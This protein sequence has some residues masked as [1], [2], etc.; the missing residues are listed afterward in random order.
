MSAEY[1]KRV[2]RWDRIATWVIT[3][4]GMAVIA[5]VILILLLIVRVAV[6]LFESQEARKFWGSSNPSTIEPD[7]VLAVGMDDYLET[8]VLLDRAGRFTFVNFA[9]DSTIGE[10][11]LEPPYESPSE[12]LAAI[13][14][15]GLGYSLLWANGAASFARVVFSRDHH[16]DRPP[17]TAFRVDTLAEFAPPEDGLIPIRTVT[18]YHD[19]RATRADLLHDNRIR[20]TQEVEETDLFG[21]V[22]RD[23]HV[24]VLDP[25]VGGEIADIFV[26]TEGLALFAGTKDGYLMR[27]AMRRVGTI[28]LTDS[29][30]AFENNRAISTLSMVFGDVSLAVGDEQGGMTV[31]FPVRPDYD[32]QRR[33][34]SH[35]HTLKSHRGPVTAISPSQRTKS[36]LS[37]GADGELH[38]DH[39]TSNKHLF[40]LRPESPIRKAALSSRANGIIGLD[41]AG[42]L[43]VWAIEGGYPEATWGTLFGKVW[44]ENYDEPAFV[45]QST[46]A[47]N[48]FE[49]KTSLVP[50]VFGSFKGTLYAMLY[51]IPLALFGA[52][53]TSQFTTARFRGVI[54]PAV[55]VMAAL[56]SVVIGFLIALWLAPIVEVHIMPFAVSLAVFP[57]CFLIFIVLWQPFRNL[58]L[59]R[60]IERGYEFIAFIPIMLLA[61]VAA[62]FIGHFVEDMLF[63]GDFHRWLFEDAGR[64]YDQRNCIIIAFGLGFAV[65]PIIFSITEDSLSNVPQRLTAA[66]MALGATRWQ[67][68]WRV[69]LPSAS[70]CI[71]AAIMIGFGRAV[72]ET[73]IVLMATGNTPLMEWSIFTGM[74]TLSANIAVEIPEAPVGGTLY[75]ILFLSAVLLFILTSIVNTAAELVRQYLRKRYAQFQ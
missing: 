40:G 70:P 50:L 6:P 58:K 54:K 67:T 49:P 5:A 9:D 13:P 20:V 11:V 10:I 74:R 71:F 17:T 61:G 55:E 32:P 21:N 66:S 44:Y 2:K 56:P 53:Y 24:S 7:T 3:G 16:V 4:G 39:M 35:I 1:R 36:L 57:A 48:A 42:R 75:R 43:N 18:R 33:V 65:I 22:S 45:W 38:M 25:A 37:L 12:I 63:A 26:D 41:D 19:G 8:G 68:V 28:E 52:I 69:V 51:A 34:L 47:T 62:Y 64:N 23:S 15:H 46:G 59:A 14:H 73:M 30:L 29:L 31:W 27:W 60:H 72:G